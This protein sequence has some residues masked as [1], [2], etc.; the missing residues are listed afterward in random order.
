MSA[1]LTDFPDDWQP[2]DTLDPE[3]LNGSGIS[4]ARD[5]SPLSSCIPP[6]LPEP[7][8]PDFDDSA[9]SQYIPDPFDEPISKPAPFWATPVGDSQG[10]WPDPVDLWGGLNLPAMPHNVLPP[11][12]ADFILDQSN[13]M[14]SD[15]VQMALNCR[16]IAASCIRTGI[17]LQ[18]Q[19]GNAEQGGR[20]WQESPILWGSVVGDPSTMK[21]PVLNASIHYFRKVANKLREKNEAAWKEYDRLTKVHE[22]AL[23][24][25][26]SAAA[27]DP[28]APQPEAPEKPPRERLWTDD[29]T[30]E[31]VAKLICENPRGKICV[32]KDEQA[33]W[34][35]SFDAYGNGK[36]DKDRPDWLS[37][38]ESG[39]R[40]I[41][42]STEGRSYHVPSW[43]G[44]I[45]GGIQPSVLAKIAGKLGSDGMLQRFMIV[46]PQAAGDE[47]E[48][49]RYDQEAVSRWNRIID[50]LIEMYP[51][52]YPVTLSDDAADFAAD[53]RRWCRN[54][55]K[56]NIDPSLNFML[57]KW[58]GLHGRLMIT[59]H[60][61]A[62]ADRGLPS[63]SPEVSLKTAQ[64]TWAWMEKVLWPHAV[65]FYT[66]L[67]TQGDD[68]SALL[69][70]AN[71]VLARNIT[72]VRPGYLSAEWSHYRKFKTIQQRREF[73][74]SATNVGIVRPKNDGF[75]RTGQIARTYE[76]NP[77]FLDGRFKTQA[78]N[79]RHQAERYREIMHPAFISKQARE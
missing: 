58:S 14:T 17:T 60:C 40:Y 68:N 1:V 8:F 10:E 20:V 29:V 73:W 4:D 18:M 42:R 54:L 44:C 63:P 12:A 30:K 77:K 13:V 2:S 56:A 53:K 35:G 7:P 59:D 16:V 79:A 71:F 61:I 70:F 49:A 36:S 45:V 21:G 33:G 48:N 76:I 34:F 37:F 38:Y 19:R 67:S 3:S 74:D 50:N 26:Y 43:G 32:I 28:N 27:K 11:A 6:D 22:R 5:G 47:N 24:T 23:Q 51:T 69:S 62:D 41:D 57:G 46:M 31:T 52:G 39:E 72:E 65:Q 78:E 66:S 25:Y 9:T 75:N 55:Q 15:P 64:T